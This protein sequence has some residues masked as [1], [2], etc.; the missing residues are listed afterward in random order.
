MM[1]HDEVASWF[2]QV[3]PTY[4]MYPDKPIFDTV[5]CITYRLAESGPEGRRQLT[6]YIDLWCALGD[7]LNCCEKVG[8]AIDSLHRKSAGATWTDY[9]D[10]AITLHDGT[11]GLAHR[12]YQFTLN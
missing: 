1:T 4:Y 11:T 2:G 5:P 7:Y 9:Y 8:Q 3:L 10:P 12:S 6:V